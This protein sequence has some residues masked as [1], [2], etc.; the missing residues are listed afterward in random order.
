[1]ANTFRKV[2]KKTGSTGTSSDYQLVGNVGVNGI[3]LDIM[4]GAS[5]NTDGE[6]GLVPKPTKGQQDYLLSGGGVWVSQ[7][8]I[9]GNSDISSIGDGTIKGSILNINSQLNGLKLVYKDLQVTTDQY[10]KVDLISY[11]L[12]EEGIVEVYP[13][14]SNYGIFHYSNN[15]IR[16][17]NIG[18]GVLSLA[19]N[20]KV[21]IYVVYMKY[22][23]RE[24]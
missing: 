12:G 5:S 18:T 11:G 10:G 2:Y 7:N 22:Y 16:I 14:S 6:I 20:A 4:K 17:F 13:Y 23:M 19:S 8:D 9:L 24:E 21:D 3:E 1:M 15:G